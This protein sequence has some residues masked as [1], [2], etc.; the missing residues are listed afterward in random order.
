MKQILKSIALGL[1]L[2]IS[3]SLLAQEEGTSTAS[4]VIIHLKS[5]TKVKGEVAEWKYGEYIII[6]MPWGSRMELPEN[7]I[8]K[9]IQVGTN[10]SNDVSYNFK[11]KGFYFSAKGQVI[12][13][14]EGNRAK[15][16][17]GFGLSV[18][19][20]HRIHRLLGI[21][22]GIGFD[23]YIWDSAEELIPLFAEIS[24]YL[25]PSHTSIFY[26]IQTGYSFAQS[27]N[28]YLLL[29]AKGGFMIY[30]SI[31]IRFGKEVTKFT[32][33]V[34]YKFQNAQFTYRDIWTATTRSEQDVLFK[35]LCI[36]FGIS[37]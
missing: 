8:K 19:G 21:G 11:E 1:C 12:T 3:S 25:T 24:G 32:L 17:Y 34:G 36:R 35:R 9:I 23:K 16:V 14:N 27:D 7:Q 30:P 13:G 18:S 37:L 22:G 5:G 15:G 20:G 29:D 4:E 10:I 28:D 2:V 31:G 6:N 26:N 33:D